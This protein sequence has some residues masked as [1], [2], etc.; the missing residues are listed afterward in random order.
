MP[1]R[2]PARTAAAATT[3]FDVPTVALPPGPGAMLGQLFGDVPG[4]GVDGDR[5]H[6]DHRRLDLDIVVPIG[7]ADPRFAVLAATVERLADRSHQG[8]VMWQSLGPLS[9]G[10]AL[11]RAGVDPVDAL[12]IGHHLVRR[13]LAEIARLVQRSLPDAAQI[14]ILHEPDLAAVA[15]RSF[16]LAMDESIDVLSCAMASVEQVASVGVHSCS[17][18]DLGVLIEAGP[19]IVSVPVRD[20]LT[21][22]AGPLV[23]YIEAGGRVAWGA[24]ATQGPVGVSSRRGIHDLLQVWAVLVRHGCDPERLVAQCVLTPSCGLGAHAPV[25]A[26]RLCGALTDVSRHL[27]SR[28]PSELVTFGR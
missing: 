8:P 9:A 17:R 2:D 6:V 20:C 1:H 12:E 5:L 16:P 10:T 14:V 3:W 7:S 21:R 28:P 22:S 26:E 19:E 4:V 13:K 27:R 25:V 11:M 23:R 15:R 18:L 24:V